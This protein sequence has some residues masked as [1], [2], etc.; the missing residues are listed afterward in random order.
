MKTLNEILGAIY[1]GRATDEDKQYY[2]DNYMTI[3]EKEIGKPYF[4]MN[5]EEK[6]KYK[7]M[8]YNN[9]V[10]NLEGYDCPKCKNRGD[11]LYINEYGYEIY[12][13]CSCKKIRSTIRKMEKSGLGNLLSIYKFDNYECTE[14]WQLD[15]YNRA[16][17]FTTSDRNWFCMLGQSGSGKSHICTAISRE[18]LK[19][20]MDLKYMMWLDEVNVLNQSISNNPERYEE[21][22]K[23]LKETQVLYIDDFFKSEN[24]ARPSAAE[25]KRANEILNYRYNKA[26]MDNYKRWI[27]I[28]SSERTIEQLLE[29]DTALGGRMVE[30]TKPDNL[31]MLSGAEKNYRLK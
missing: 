26:R 4:Q 21:M 18:L 19:Q 3:E 28:I 31:I 22:M 12:P 5:S 13:D 25:I 27:T 7:V 10:G 24:E 8:T 30:M 6:I 9:S 20:G 1:T 23:E 14:D 15:T 17:D 29:Y 2:I 16:K 11:F